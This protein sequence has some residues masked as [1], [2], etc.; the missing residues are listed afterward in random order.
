MTAAMVVSGI[1]DLAGRVGERA[2]PTAWRD[3]TQELIDQFADITNDHQWIHVDVERSRAQSPFG[4]TVAHGDLTLSLLDGFSQELLRLDDS[5]FLAGA[6]YG[7]NRV[8]F[9]APVPSGSRVR[10]TGELIEVTEVGGGWWQLVTRYTVE[11]EGTEKPAVVA[12]AVSRLLTTGAA[13]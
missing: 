9:P 13:S 1:E 8:R 10:A 2:G 3:V 7:W 4:S 12:D 6:N 11:I 5:G